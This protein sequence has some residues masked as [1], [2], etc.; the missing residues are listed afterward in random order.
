MLRHRRAQLL[1]RMG[2]RRRF[3]EADMFFVVTTGR[4][5]SQTIAETLSQHPAI[6]CAH[7]PHPELISLSTEY[8]HGEKSSDAV[9]AELRE[10]YSRRVY[11]RNRWVGESDQKCW[12]LIPFLAELI[13]ESRFIWLIRDGRDVVASTYSQNWFPTRERPGS[14]DSANLYDRW[15]YYRLNGAKCGAMSFEE[16]HAMSEFGKNCWHWIHINRGIE[17]QLAALPQDRVRQVKLEELGEALPGLV[18]WLGLKAVTINTGVHNKATYKVRRWEAWNDEERQAFR[19]WC[20]AGM[21]EWYPGWMTQAGCSI[22]TA[23]ERR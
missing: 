3:E 16:W 15:L 22:Q 19:K 5:G 13:P 10:I 8:A 12:N 17:R 14:P 21:D 11:P 20:G 23:D 1:A 7:E 6:E 18:N 4:S 2:F 9:R